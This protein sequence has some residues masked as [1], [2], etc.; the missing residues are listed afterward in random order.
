MRSQFNLFEKVF[1]EYVYA[2][3]Y[4]FNQLAYL[5]AF[6]N[7]LNTFIDFIYYLHMITQEKVCSFLTLHH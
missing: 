7:L 5:A 6:I 1:S 4:L 3:I 2:I